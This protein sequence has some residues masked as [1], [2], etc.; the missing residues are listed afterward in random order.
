MGREDRGTRLGVRCPAMAV[1]DLEVCTPSSLLDIDL[2]TSHDALALA[3]GH[4]TVE[5]CFSGASSRDRSRSPMREETREYRCPT[6]K[7]EEKAAGGARRSRSPKTRSSAGSCHSQPLDSRDALLPA[8]T[9]H[10]QPRLAELWAL[11]SDRA[12]V[13]GMGS[14]YAGEYSLS[15]SFQNKP[16]FLRIDDNGNPDLACIY[17]WKG[18]ADFPEGWYIGNRKNFSLR[19]LYCASPASWPPREGWTFSPSPGCAFLLLGPCAVT[20]GCGNDWLPFDPSDAESPADVLGSTA[21]VTRLFSNPIGINYCEFRAPRTESNPGV[22]YCDNAR[23][24]C[25]GGLTL[26]SNYAFLTKQFLC[27]RFTNLLKNVRFP[28]SSALKFYWRLLYA[29]APPDLLKPLIQRP[30]TLESNDAIEEAPQPPHFHTYALNPAQLRSLSWM[31]RREAN[32]AED[33][34]SVDWRGYE[35]V[36][37]EMDSSKSLQWLQVGTEVEAITQSQKLKRARITWASQP[38][39]PTC[40][41]VRWLTWEGADIWLADPISE[42]SQ[43]EELISIKDVR[44]IRMALD[45]RVSADYILSGGILANKI[46]FGKT[47]TTLGLI[48]TTLKKPRNSACEPDGFIPAKGTLILVPSNLHVQWLSEIGKFLYGDRR[49]HPMKGSWS[50]SDCPLRIFAPSTITPLTKATASEIADAD[51]VLCSYNF[52]FSGI[53]EHRRLELTK[54]SFT[55]YKEL[56]RQTR[57]LQKGTGNV[58]NGYCKTRTAKGL[59]VACTE[60]ELVFPVLEMFAWNRIVLDEVHELERM[61]YSQQIFLQHLRAKHRWGLTGTPPISS[62]A[63]ILF[64]SSL[65]QIDLVGILRSTSGVADLSACEASPVITELANEFC[66]CFVRQE[67]EM[68]EIKIEEH[69]VLL[70]QSPAERALYL[71]HAHD[72]PDPTSPGTFTTEANTKAMETLLQLC[73]H[74]QARSDQ[75]GNADKECQRIRQQKQRRIRLARKALSWYSDALISLSRDRSARLDQ[76]VQAMRD[77]PAAASKEAAQAFIDSDLK[78]RS[79]TYEQPLNDRLLLVL[80]GRDKH[81]LRTARDLPRQEMQERIIEILVDEQLRN[82]AELRDAIS[83]DH[84]FQKVITAISEDSEKSCSVC[85]D[86]NIPLHR[87]A[88]TTCGHTF[89]KECLSATIQTFGRCGLCKQQLRAKDQYIVSHLTVPAA[90]DAL[91][92]AHGTK[93][94][95]LAEELRKIR[96]E[97]ATAKA[98]LFVQFG[99][100]KAKVASA[101]TEYNIGNV[102]LCGTSSQRGNIIRDWQERGGKKRS[103][104]IFG[105]FSAIF[106]AIFFDVNYKT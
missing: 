91:S 66:K 12:P 20:P 43:E 87:L 19:T 14:Y 63:G 33:C 1:N 8:S 5:A 55:P 84:Y 15:A 67:P 52:L 82:L 40:F 97:D 6:R 83:S 18:C 103:Y 50:P 61:N 10:I 38:A 41:K 68:L 23:R 94:T 95:M 86:E 17:F 99:E 28:P 102:Q 79:K 16:T 53:Y 47:A 42:A 71:G 85:M 29:H 11:V 31:L 70:Q 35:W 57:M 88:I 104:V 75:G 7:M 2:N 78:A 3:N 73:S 98:I 45:Y 46:G 69:L 105:I 32:T 60:K 21:W 39:P 93:L 26:S 62:T 106:S 65:F 54:M 44:R 36:K 51:I 22:H 34:I 59:S 4:F 56:I 76:E 101:L 81:F 24:T 100:L 64:M 27:E 49:L 80:C 77:S 13:S 89:C 92:A 30:F 96:Q 9:A 74:F 58:P 48:D 72:A 25:P 37:V 90:T